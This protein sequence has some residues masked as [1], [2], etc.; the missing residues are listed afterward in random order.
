MP[1]KREKLDIKCGDV[2]CKAD[3]HSFVQKKPRNK[4]RPI[5]TCCTTCGVA[6]LNW[7]ILR[8]RDIGNIEELVSSFRKEHIRAYFWR[9]ELSAVSTH[10][11]VQ[12]GRGWMRHRVRKRLTDSIGSTCHFREGRQT[13]LVEDDDPIHYAQHATATC[14]RKCVFCWHGIPEGRPLKEDE[15]TY[16]E[17]IVWRYL[18][19]KLPALND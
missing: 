19:E 17:K 13:P 16:L 3:E 14:C 9:F 18:D 10:N 8:R 5:P 6:P 12:K 15:L 4:P 2:D 1:K 7:E 11:P